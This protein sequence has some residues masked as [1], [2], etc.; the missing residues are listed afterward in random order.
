MLAAAPGILGR[1]F[2]KD[3]ATADQF[4]GSIEQ[5]GTSK[6]SMLIDWQN[7]NSVEI[8]VILRSPV[9]I[10]RAKGI[11]IAEETEPVR[12]RKIEAETAA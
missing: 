11:E 5:S 2:P 6:P 8:E 3:M 7:G 1:P 10:A 9:R 4:L 12:I